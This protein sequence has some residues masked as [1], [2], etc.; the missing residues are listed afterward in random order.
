MKVIF[1]PLFPWFS[2]P[3]RCLGC[4]NTA[5]TIQG[6]QHHRLS[7]T[8]LS[9]SSPVFLSAMSD[10]LPHLTVRLPP[11]AHRICII[12]NADFINPL[13]MCNGTV[14][15]NSPPLRCTVCQK[16]E[17]C[18]RCRAIKKTKHFRRE[19]S[20][21]QLYRTCARCREHSAM[22][23]RQKQIQAEVLGM[24]SHCSV[25]LSLSFH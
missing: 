4:C 13:S 23:V 12:C 17:K 8:G 18:S 5:R 1:F 9:S 10:V 15:S 14:D 21:Q 22:L 25:S 24:R 19:G 7:Q 11:H 16:C 6:L 3:C 2:L 20:C